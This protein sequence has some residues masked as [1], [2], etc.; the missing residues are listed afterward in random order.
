MNMN[1]CFN[2]N[3]S[4]R[5]LNIFE[6]LNRGESVNKDN[7]A[8]EYN[9]S[10]KTIQRDIDDIRAYLSETHFNE[11]EISIKYDKGKNSYYLVRL[12]REWMTNVEALSICKILLE[13]RAFKKNEI[14]NLT[15]KLIMQI[16]PTDRNVIREII[17]SELVNYVPLQH[18]KPLMNTIWEISKYI[19]SQNIISFRYTRQ[20][21]TSSIK[22][23]KPV[24]VMFSEFY[25]YLVAFSEDKEITHPI[26]YRIDRMENLK[27]TGEKFS[28]P[29]RD[30][31]SDGEFRKRIQFM[32]SGD[33]KRVTFEYSGV[34]EAIL[35]RL[36]T[37][38]VINEKDGVYTITAESYG[39]G[40]YMWLRSQGDLV[41]IL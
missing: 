3:K 19:I 26:I 18:G 10:L 5:L 37:A 4:F 31:F 27:F 23:V 28:I 7:L 22:S 33:L 6:R 11:S 9:V 35:D 21:G 38:K 2:I 30:R 41:K 39:D 25:F 36:P 20:D 8:S 12:E 32:Y 16:S 1:D 29:Y 17:G 34:L 15:D 24:S 13:S 14:M 40:I